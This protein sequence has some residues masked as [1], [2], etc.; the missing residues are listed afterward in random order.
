VGLSINFKNISHPNQN[1]FREKNISAGHLL[2]IASLEKT[3]KYNFI[4]MRTFASS[5]EQRISGG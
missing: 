4:N 3:Q 1:K 2:P 5:A